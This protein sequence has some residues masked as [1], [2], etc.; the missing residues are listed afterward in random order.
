MM[1]DTP[2][3][4]NIP[5][6][7]L[8]GKSLGLKAILMHA[9]KMGSGP[10]GPESGAHGKTIEVPTGNSLAPVHEESRTPNAAMLNSQRMNSNQMNA[11]MGGMSVGNAPIDRSQE[12]GWGNINQ[13][14]NGGTQIID[15]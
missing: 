8:D 10:G 6:G 3:N 13:N 11:R 12:G 2:S 7:R 1:A 5:N 14:R 15:E 4:Y 9:K